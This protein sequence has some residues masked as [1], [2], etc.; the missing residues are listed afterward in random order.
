MRIAELGSRNDRCARSTNAARCVRTYVVM[1]N[2][3]ADARLLLRV[4]PAEYV[5]ERARLVKQARADGDRARAAFYQSLNHPN[6]SLWAVLAAGGDAK[7]VRGVVSAT[8]ELA[9]IQATRSDP[10]AVTAATKHRRKA[11]EA[12]VDG[13]V[14]ALAQ[15]ER[16]AEARRAEI[17]GIVDQLSRHSDVVEAWIDATLRDLPDDAWGFGAFADMEVTGG[18]ESS[19]PPTKKSKPRAGAGGTAIAEPALP[20]KPTRAER[21]ERTKQARQDVAAAKRDLAA[22]ERRVSEA[23]KAVRDAEKEMRLAEA[24]QATVEKRVERAE[25]DLATVAFDG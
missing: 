12:L 3:D 8:E 18:S 23:R 6:L 5:A 14:S 10:A 15:W 9:K 19:A 11:L 22:A 20:A 21:A 7:E 17:R 1:A 2:E 25:A 24:D 13:A 16:G 4:A